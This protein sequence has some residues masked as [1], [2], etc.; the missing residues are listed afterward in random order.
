MDERMAVLSHKIFWKGCVSPSPWPGELSHI[1]CGKCGEGALA[2]K[3]GPSSSTQTHSQIWETGFSQPS[4]TLMTNSLDSLLST[5]KVTNYKLIFSRLLTFLRYSSY[6]SPL[7]ICQI[8]TP[9]S[10]TVRPC[11]TPE[12][13]LQW[14]IARLQ[15]NSH[16]L[17]WLAA[18][19][20]A[21]S[22]CPLHHWKPE[23]TTHRFQKNRDKIRQHSKKRLRMAF[24]WYSALILRCEPWNTHRPAEKVPMNPSP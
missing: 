23:E 20:H 11:G 8:N 7:V 2:F 1:T 15:L 24:C 9:F 4:G 10:P 18:R 19:T 3:K 16:W 12:D 13:K 14:P 5:A 22:H 6:F 17:A 21:A